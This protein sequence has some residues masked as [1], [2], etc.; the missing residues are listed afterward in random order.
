MRATSSLL[1]VRGRRPRTEAPWRTHS[2]PQT[3]ISLI[4]RLVAVEVS[5]AGP[6]WPPFRPWLKVTDLPSSFV[7]FWPPSSSVPFWPPRRPWR[8]V[9][10]PFSSYP[11]YHAS[12]EIKI[13]GI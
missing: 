2:L 6:F 1:V 4:C 7:P 8:Q 12:S 5:A 13:M 11:R 3:G 9:T 10:L